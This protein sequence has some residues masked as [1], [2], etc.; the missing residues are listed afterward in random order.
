MQNFVPEIKFVLKEN[1]IRRQVR[2][3]ISSYWR[4]KQVEYLQKLY[5]SKTSTLLNQ[6]ITLYYIVLYRW[7][8]GWAF[9]PPGLARFFQPDRFYLF[10]RINLEYSWPE[11]SINN[12]L[13]SKSNNVVNTLMKFSSIRIILMWFPYLNF[14]CWN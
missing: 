12:G 1:H 7:N 10:L 2:I 9:G 6:Y 11:I 4:N 3:D 14:E 13:I 5:K 8:E